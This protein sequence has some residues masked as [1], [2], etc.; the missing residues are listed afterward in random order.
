MNELIKTY[1][2]HLTLRN[3]MLEEL[4]K[5]LE[6]EINFSNYLINCLLKILEAGENNI[7]EDKIS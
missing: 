6:A 1:L 5:Q 7:N 4:T 2:R 3:S